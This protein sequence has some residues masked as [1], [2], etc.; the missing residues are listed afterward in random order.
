MYSQRSSTDDP[1]KKFYIDKSNVIFTQLM[2]FKL[3][4]ILFHGK[5]LNLP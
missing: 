1:R 2:I 4:A 5:N 3:V